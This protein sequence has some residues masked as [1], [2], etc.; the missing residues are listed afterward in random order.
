MEENEEIEF[1]G[2]GAQ[3]DS[4]AFKRELSGTSSLEG[5]MQVSLPRFDQYLKSIAHSLAIIAEEMEIRGS[6]KNANA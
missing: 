1:K 6:G 5:M 2:A 4:D 3:N